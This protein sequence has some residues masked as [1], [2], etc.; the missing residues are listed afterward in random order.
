MIIPRVERQ[1]VAREQDVTYDPYRSCES[2]CTHDTARGVLTSD[3]SHDGPFADFAD[4]WL[5]GDSLSAIARRMRDWQ[6]EQ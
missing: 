2:T 4:A 5:N 6:A 1:L 3:L